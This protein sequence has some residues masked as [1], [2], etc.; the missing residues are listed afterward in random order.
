MKVLIVDDSAAE[1][2]RLKAIVEHAGHQTVLAH[3]GEEAL[4]VAARERPALIFMDIVMPKMDGFRATRE[5][6]A[7]PETRAIPVVLVS[8][9]NEAA[10]V[11]WAKRQ[12][13]A[14]L[15]GKP[16]ATAEILE[17]LIRFQR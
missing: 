16:Y 1:L 4:E 17:Q 8:T 5:L 15:V 12:G 11:L 9:K 2:A 14:H 6:A 10:D 7:R 13:A 3:N